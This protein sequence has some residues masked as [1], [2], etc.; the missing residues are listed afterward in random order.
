MPIYFLRDLSGFSELGLYTA[1]SA[2]AAAGVI[3]QSVFMTSFTPAIYR[4]VHN[5]DVEDKHDKLLNFALLL[6]LFIFLGYGGFA[7][8]VDYL[9]PDVYGEVVFIFL[10]AVIAP[11]FSTISE[12][13]SVGI[14]VSK[15]TYYSMFSSF[16]AVCLSFVFCSFLVP[17]YGASG[18][19]IAT[20]LAYFFYVV[21]KVEMAVRVWFSVSRVKV[22]FFCS[23]LLVT[24]IFIAYFKVQYF[25]MYFWVAFVVFCS[26]FWK[27]VRLIY[28]EARNA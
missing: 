8:V 4:A 10:L 17:S 23:V 27:K 12:V 26:L 22:Y 9:L 1:A 18:A 19:A 21:I 7:W 16:L 15:K 24:S 13:A 3:F 14:N 28:V 11:L 20:A 25:Y 5:G 2:L 6:S